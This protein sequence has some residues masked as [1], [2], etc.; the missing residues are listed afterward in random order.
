MTLNDMLAERARIYDRMQD[1]QNRFNDKP[2]EGADK[3]TYGNLETEFD[4]M[5]AK[6][7][8]EKKKLERERLMGEKAP[9]N[10]PA[11]TE[12]DVL[13]AFRNHLRIGDSETMKAY[14]ALQ[15]DNPS[16]AG[17]LIAPE[18]FVG[19]MIKEL[20]DA[21][22]FRTLAKKFS[23]KG[24]HSM[25][26]PKRI[27]RTNTFRWG[28]EVSEPT[29]DTSLAF[30]KREFV[31]H[32]ASFL[33][34]VSNTLIQNAPEVDAIVRSELV[35]EVAKNLEEAYM[36]GDGVNKPLGVFTAGANG[37]STARDVA[38]DNTA[39]AMTF[40]GLIEAKYAI[41][42]QYQP[43]AKWLFHRDAVK[44]LAKIK[45]SD[46]Q[47]IWQPSVVAG[48]PDML[49]GKPVMMSEYV[50]HT[51]SA[52]QYVGMLGDFSNYWICDGQDMFIQ[53]LREKYALTNQIGY[54]GRL[55]T[56]GM[57]VLDEPFARIKLAASSS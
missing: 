30:G 11:R 24:A 31:P 43:N 48:T 44:M 10:K 17:Y 18:K 3:D 34:R 33:I 32:P 39:T 46:G 7:E 35:A 26:F 16:Q 23:L 6:I 21:V 56:D 9:E 57:A 45:D 49:L 38:T 40:N 37:I 42:S 8:A 52:N 41:K 4:S 50:P 36:T 20:D 29:E 1:I 5:T 15:M 22:F 13:D 19:T 47:Y 53:V 2:M 14:N 54:I 27:E 28:S 12:N 25:G 55:A 51:F